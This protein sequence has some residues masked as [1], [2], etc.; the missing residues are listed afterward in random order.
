MELGF[1]Q[2]SCEL[3]KE[4]IMFKLS[5]AIQSKTL[6]EFKAKILDVI[7][8]SADD[9]WLSADVPISAPKDM[10]VSVLIEA[11]MEALEE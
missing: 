5:R 11:L 2:I 7:S 10:F 3:L 6:N 9:I 1:H 8:G 4:V